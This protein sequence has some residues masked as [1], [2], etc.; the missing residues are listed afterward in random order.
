MAK[1]DSS[2]VVRPLAVQQMG[3][4]FM[5]MNVF[6]PKS[7]TVPH[8]IFSDIRVRRAL[9]MAVDRVGM[10]QNVFGDKGRLG[11]GPFPM[12]LSGRRQH[13]ARSSL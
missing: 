1:L 7:K 2:T 4:G 12:T 13:A 5:T 10:L 8:P 9:S 11:H 6:A 3:Y